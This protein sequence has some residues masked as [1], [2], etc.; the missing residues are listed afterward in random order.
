MKAYK[1]NGYLI[2]YIYIIQ[3]DVVGKLFLKMLK[4]N[5]RRE[6]LVVDH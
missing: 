1:L 6:Q 4:V 2:I 3:E 5:S